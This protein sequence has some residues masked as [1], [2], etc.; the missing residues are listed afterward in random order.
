L[1]TSAGDGIGTSNDRRLPKRTNPGHNGGELC[2]R[3]LSGMS[4]AERE[5][6]TQ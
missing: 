1:S 5:A 2:G 4:L 3:T 6:R